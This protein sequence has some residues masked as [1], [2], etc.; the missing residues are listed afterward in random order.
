LK[1]VP[2]KTYQFGVKNSLIKTYP[3]IVRPLVKAPSMNIKKI[4]KFMFLLK[5]KPVMHAATPAIESEK[6]HFLPILSEMR[7]RKRT[8]HDQ[9]TKNILPIDPSLFLLTQI[10]SIYSTQLCK[11]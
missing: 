6:I 9:P 7:G 11:L 5:S 8:V 2:K 10:K 4:V 1:A 3:T